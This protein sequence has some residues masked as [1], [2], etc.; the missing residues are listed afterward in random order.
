MIGLLGTAREDFDGTGHV[1]VH[2]EI[3]Q[4][5]STVPLTNGQSIRVSNRNGLT[6]QVDPVQ[7]NN[8]EALP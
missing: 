1:L 4:A 7:H 2:G 3:W 8:P 6:L 5:V